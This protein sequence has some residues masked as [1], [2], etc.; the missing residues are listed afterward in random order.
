VSPPDVFLNVVVQCSSNYFR[1]YQQLSI[2]ARAIMYT[3]SERTWN[4]AAGRVRSSVLGETQK[5][6]VKPQRT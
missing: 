1:H 5:N 2:K 6:W 4:K 3:E